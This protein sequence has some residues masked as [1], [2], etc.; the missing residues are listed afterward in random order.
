MPDHGYGRGDRVRVCR[1]NDDY[2]GCTGTVKRLSMNGQMLFVELD[3]KP[4]KALLFAPRWVEPERLEIDLPILVDLALSA[5]EA[6][7]A[8][9]K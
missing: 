5:E 7:K 9:K 6:R 4:G 3:I 1:V 8:A 2:A